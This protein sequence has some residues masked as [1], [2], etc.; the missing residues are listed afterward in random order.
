[1]IVCPSCGEENPERARFCLA[2]GTAL[3]QSAAVPAGDVRKTVTVVFSDVTGSTAIGERLDPETLRR[4]MTRYFDEMRDAV[5]AHGGVVEKFIGDA[6]MAVF[7][8]PRLHED[9]ALR[10]VRA[11]DEMRSRLQQLNGGL[12]RD[13]GVELTVRTGVN[14]GEVVSGDVGAG[15]RLVTGDAVNVAARL[16]QAAAPGEILLGATTHALVRDAVDAT[17]LDRPLELKGKAEPVSA[18]RLE[19]VTPGASGHA[20]RLD[21]PMVGRERQRRLLDESFDQAVSERVCYLFTVL[22]SAGVGKSRLVNEFLDS[23]RATRTARLVHGR[24]LSYGEGITFWPVAEAI[25]GAAGIG[26][27]EPAAGAVAGVRTLFGDDPEGDALASQVAG[28]IGLAP[29][30]APAEEAFRAIRRAFELMAAQEPLVVVFDDIHWAQPAFLDLIEHLADWSRDAP[31]LLICLARQELL[32]ARPAWAGGKRAAT[33]IQLEPLSDDESEALIANL[34]G[35]AGLE[36]EAGRRIA[37]AAEGNPLFVEEMVE[38]LIDDGLLVRHNAHWE[39]VGDLAEV[40]VPPTIQALLAARLERLD[41]DERSVMERGAVEGK[42]FHRGAVLELAPDPVRSGVTSHLMALVRKELVRPDRPTFA[43]EEAFRFRHLLIRDAAYQ[44]M[45]K[46][47]RGDLHGRFAG[48]LERVAGDRLPEYEEIVAYHL[49]QAYR[50]REELGPIDASSRDLG[51]R[52]AGHLSAAATRA[53]S[54][55][56]VVATR[57]LLA[58]ASSLLADGDPERL[59]LQPLLGRAMFESGEIEAAG[60]LLDRA[61]DEAERAGDR[62]TAAWARV[63]AMVVGAAIGITSVSQVIEQARATAAMFEELGDE[64]GVASA[65]GVMGQF[66]FFGGSCAESAAT[67]EEARRRAEAAGRT[68]QAFDATWWIAA[69]LFFGPTPASECEAN[70]LAAEAR[71]RG[72]RSAEAA[73]HRAYARVLTIQ[74]R[75]DEARASIRAWEEIERELGRTMRLA[76]IAGHYLGPLEMAAGRYAEAVEAGRTGFEAQSSLGDRGYSATVAGVLAHALL[77]VGDDA[78]A[79]RFAREAVGR[80]ADD[81]LEPKMSGNGAIGVALARQ[82]N[83]AEGER[84][85]RLG[86]DVARGT[87]YSVNLAEAL[88]DLAEVLAIGGRR[89][90]A[91]A[92]VDEAITVLERKE[93]WALV[94]RAREARDAL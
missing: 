6:V 92:L 19:G 25:K 83:V 11:A 39:P 40:A 69:A 72:T 61:A 85:A 24:C 42:V 79:E 58:R 21:S 12:Q 65:Y 54:R 59:R 49:E 41:P 51:R 47:T 48:W 86:V 90:E 36:A 46:E 5:Q 50:Y 93:A 7:G 34:L 37:A 30:E 2:C 29:A 82:G 74:G 68:A 77:M 88:V 52:A 84:H 22:G 45:P 70:L 27:D 28:L 18:W 20:R 26:D 38:M 17:Q 56:D 60:E 94:D 57:G 67:L 78:E 71:T 14:T 55:G 43:G 15:Q 31:I 53:E 44:A 9:D 66:Q 35:S 32:E 62:S 4:V 80:S 8:I 73:F 89:D 3:D 13:H 91:L 64:G 23:E 75:F 76:S 87:D 81:D 1:V 33:T 10:A 16:E 63:N